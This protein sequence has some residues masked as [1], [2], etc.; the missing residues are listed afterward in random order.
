M[1]KGSDL[2]P[3]DT[4]GVLDVFIRLKQQ[5]RH[6]RYG[7]PTVMYQHGLIPP[8]LFERDLSAQQAIKQAA[9]MPVSMRHRYPTVEGTEPIWSRLPGE[10]DAFFRAF[11]LYVTSHERVLSEVVDTFPDISPQT[12]LELFEFYYWDDR[13]RAYDILRP[14]VAA[15]L[16]DQR[17]IS[18]E[19]DHY[20]AAQGV[21]Q[22]ALKELARRDSEDGG[23]F[24]GTPTKDLIEIITKMA[25]LQ[26]VALRL[27]AKGPAT[28]DENRRN[29]GP[30]QHLSDAVNE[31][32]GGGHEED[33]PATRLRKRV[34]ETIA[35]SEESAEMLQSVA[36]QL[37]TQKDD[38]HSPSEE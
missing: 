15:R 17:M 6:D 9:S 8:D 18:M 23:A 37:L 33:S 26:R 31:Y 10:P 14:A 29:A 38:T 20:S 28:K 30:Q 19:D 25:E 1:S 35:N 3:R 11:R 27:P 22:T 32:E 16:R 24:A 2:V 36:I 7:F 21:L 4:S 13:A 12:V 5:A 34:Q